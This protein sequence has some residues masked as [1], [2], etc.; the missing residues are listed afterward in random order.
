MKDSRE[1]AYLKSLP[2]ELAKNAFWTTNH[3]TFPTSF[4]SKPREVNVFPNDEPYAIE[5]N[6]DKWEGTDKNYTIH[7]R[8]PITSTWGRHQHPPSPSKYDPQHTLLSRR[9][10]EPSISILDR[11][12]Y[13]GKEYTEAVQLAQTHK[14]PEFLQ[15][16]ES[17]KLHDHHSFIKK[18]FNTTTLK[19]IAKQ[20][21]PQSD[22]QKIN[23]EDMRKCKCVLFLLSLMSYPLYDSFTT[24]TMCLSSR[25][26]IRFTRSLRT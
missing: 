23:I 18:S 3:G 16:L 15:S 14:Q 13:K 20:R 19:E 25:R 26:Q 12:D 7:G 9:E 22:L 5:K 4:G 21:K 24:R 8:I 17:K 6:F 1:A 2:P 10:N 11:H